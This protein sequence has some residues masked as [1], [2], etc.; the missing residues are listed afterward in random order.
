MPTELKFDDLDLR[1]QPA[2]WAGA[3]APTTTTCNTM[4]CTKTTTCT[5]PCCTIY[6]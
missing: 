2:G 3:D 1:E 5:E 6:P 4:N